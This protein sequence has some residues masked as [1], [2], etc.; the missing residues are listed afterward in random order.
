MTRGGSNVVFTINDWDM[1]D[2]VGFDVGCCW[3][4]LSVFFLFHPHMLLKV[5]QARQF[6]DL[7][8]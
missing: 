8:P 7:F 3:L 1:Q 6:P 2:A 4:Y 5:L